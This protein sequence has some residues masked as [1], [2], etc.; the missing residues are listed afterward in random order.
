MER[1]GARNAACL[2]CGAPAGTGLSFCKK[3]GATLGAPVSLMSSGS[4]AP[5]SPV[6]TSAMK[7]TG[8][9]IVKGIAAV[10]AVVF[11]FWVPNTGTQALVFGVSI[12]VLLICVA[13]LGNLDDN[14]INKHIK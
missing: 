4:Q 2:Q 7:R 8:I 3:C 10:A 14:F 13:V 11:W 12:V 5:D 6:R 1:T 9:M